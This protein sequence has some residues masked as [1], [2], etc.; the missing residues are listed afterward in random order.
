VKPLCPSRPFKLFADFLSCYQ[1]MV[2]ESPYPHETLNGFRSLLSFSHHFP[3]P[4][5]SCGRHYQKGF[6]LVAENTSSRSL[7]RAITEFITFP[8]WPLALGNCDMTNFVQSFCVMSINKSGMGDQCE[9][10][11]LI[12]LAIIENIPLFLGY[13]WYISSHWSSPN[14]WSS[15]NTRLCCLI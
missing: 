8:L 1:H 11:W 13:K 5:S 15:S 7:I 12:L 2:Y 10:N 3:F 9:K 14:S 4:P 6:Y